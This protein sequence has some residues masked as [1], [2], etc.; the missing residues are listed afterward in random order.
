MVMVSHVQDVHLGSDCHLHARGR[1][2]HLGR[3][4]RRLR[5]N[6]NVALS[7][8][9][10]LLAGVLRTGVDARNGLERRDFP[11]AHLA[12]ELTAAARLRGCFILAPA[13][14]HGC[15]DTGVAKGDEGLVW[16]RCL[17]R[18]VVSES[19]GR[20]QKTDVLERPAQTIGLADSRGFCEQELAATQ[21]AGNAMILVRT[22]LRTTIK[23]TRINT[24]IYRVLSV[25]TGSL[26]S[27]VACRR[28]CRS[29]K[30]RSE[31]DV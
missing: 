19:F 21:K 20:I 6:R 28:M 16:A 2:V 15:G 29:D 3:P 4:L 22:K 18:K 31:T 1:D 7:G 8:L 27:R 11:F 17:F 10:P 5:H 30:D 14:L 24:H 26:E 25:L 23:H 9:V 13:R 12:V